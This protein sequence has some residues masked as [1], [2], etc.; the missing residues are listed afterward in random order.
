MGLVLPAE[1]LSV[2]YAAPVRRFLFGR[3]RDVE[4]VLFDE[5]VLPAAEV[6]ADVG[7]LLADGYLEGPA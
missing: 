6:E 1:L 2:N 4:L 7:L 5:Q 3:F